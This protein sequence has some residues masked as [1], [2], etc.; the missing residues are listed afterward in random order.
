MSEITKALIAAQ[1]QMQHAELDAENP[2]FGSK[3]ASLKSVIDA[4]KDALN[5]NGIAYLQQSEPSEGGVTVTTTLNHESGETLSGG[6]VFVPADKS[7]AHGYGSALTY[8]KRYSLAM[9]CGIS[10]DVDDDAN[11]AITD[12]AEYNQ[13]VR[14][15][16][17]TVAAVKGGIQK[18]PAQFDGDED[19]YDAAAEAWYELTNTQK[20]SLWLAPTKGGIFTTDERRIM[21]E[22]L[23][24]YLERS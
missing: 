24:K 23:P 18:G 9:T 6:P 22:D 2:H 13:H 12:L 5:E 21:K 4:V 14:E 3:Y 17:E 16:W 1:Q 7:T 8:A 20:Q 19:G 15:L 11:A 10:A